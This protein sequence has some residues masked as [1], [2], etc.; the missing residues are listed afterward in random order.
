M[1]LKNC[2]WSAKLSPVLDESKF[3]VSYQ[4]QRFLGI[5]QDPA[6]DVV[7]QQLQA[8]SRRPENVE[9]LPSV[10]QDIYR[11]LDLRVKIGNDRAQIQE[12]FHS[13]TTKECLLVDKMFRSA[14]HLAMEF[15]EECVGSHL[16]RV[17][18]N[19]R[20]FDALLSTIDMKKRF[21]TR[22]FLSTLK[23]IHDSTSGKLKKREFGEVMKPPEI[24]DQCSIGR[25]VGN[26]RSASKRYLCSRYQPFP[27]NR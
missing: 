27:E 8:I 22:D 11:F 3:R 9:K 25:F 12:F 13:P 26:A 21:S 20:G 7:L 6:V 2:H 18:S 23:C 10:C 1:C 15:E 16:F 17:P 14:D 19:L 4:V 5:V 24:S